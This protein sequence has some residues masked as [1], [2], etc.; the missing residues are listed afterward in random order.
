L[1]A[2]Q[3]VHD[4]SPS[5]LPIADD[6]EERMNCWQW[7]WRR[8]LLTTPALMSLP[9]EDLKAPIRAALRGA[10]S[11]AD[12]KPRSSSATARAVH[13]AVP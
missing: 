12:N 6:R 7:R 10:C 8:V 9:D 4:R 3:G 5:L 1:L 2:R 11:G 13:G